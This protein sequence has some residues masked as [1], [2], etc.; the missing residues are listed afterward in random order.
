MT[1]PGGSYIWAKATASM[2]EGVPLDIRPVTP[3]L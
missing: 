3:Y 2:I 1:K